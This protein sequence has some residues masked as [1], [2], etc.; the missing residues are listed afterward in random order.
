MAEVYEQR[1]GTA[2]AE[3]TKGGD[4]QEIVERAKRCF[5][6]AVA[7]EKD[8]RDQAIDD[9]KFLLGDQW[10]EKIR[11]ERELERRPCLSMNMLP[12]F[13]EQVLGDARQNKPAIAVHPVDNKSDPEVAKI[14]EGLIRDI[15]YNSQAH[16]ARDTALEQAVN[17]GWGYYRVVTDYC[18]DD[19]FDQEIL[20]KRIPNQFTVYYDPAAKDADYS[21]AQWCLI[22]ERMNEDDFKARWPEA[23]G[24]DTDVAEGDEDPDW[25]NSD[26]VRVGEYWVKQ[27]TKKTLALISYPGMDGRTPRTSTVEIEKDHEI[28]TDGMTG[29][30]RYQI[31]KTRQVDSHKVCCYFLT[32]AEVLEKKDWA[33]KYIPIVAVLGKEMFVE[34]NRY[35]RGLVRFAKDAQ[36]AHNYWWT[37]AT[38][39]V[40]LAPKSPWLLTAAQV[41]GYE[42]MWNEAHSKNRPYMLYNR[43]DAAPMDK[44][45]RERPPDV[46]NAMLAMLQQ[47]AQGLKDTTGIYDASLGAQG[48]EQSGVA[49]T[50]RQREGDTGTFFFID[51]LTRAITY[52]GRILVDLIPKIYDAERIVRVRGKDDTQSQFIPVNQPVVA[53]EDG[54]YRPATP[55]ELVRE[56]MLQE[57]FAFQPDP[58]DLVPIEIFDLTAG[59]YDVRV[60]VGPAYETKRIEAAQ[61][62]LEFIKAVP[63]AAPLL[64]DLIAKN[65][66]WEGAEEVSERLKVLVPG[67]AGPSPGLAAPGA[68]PPGQMP[69]GATAMAPP[70]M[71]A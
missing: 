10:P 35:L 41:Q 3:K 29:Q 6:R 23:Q 64:G 67:T 44:P 14:I 69:P 22:T 40:A 16:A 48:N 39:L 1:T 68:V 53:L 55:E 59:K 5:E 7:A 28:P 26:G 38:E 17:A 2:E 51:N 50:A 58:E 49:I 70:M 54:S 63:N 71:A 21:D 24:G 19:T 61:S 43:D 46:P 65:L 42:G 15:E 47:S 13:T 31:V 52:E 8:N 20:I 62:M 25:F 4:S 33:G 9:L 11:N 18:G 45:S 60:S 34:G 27:P 56:E 66:D 30:P 37:M 32:G 57:Q 12:K 36:R